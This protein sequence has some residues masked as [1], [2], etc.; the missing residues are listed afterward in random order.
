MS[1]QQILVQ[2]LEGDVALLI[3]ATDVLLLHRGI[4]EDLLPLRRSFTS[5]QVHRRD[6]VGLKSLHIGVLSLDAL[7]QDWPV[8]AIVK[9]VTVDLNHVVRDILVVDSCS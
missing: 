5:I 7:L 2:G 1:P 6:E 4:H 8:E 3:Q 9:S